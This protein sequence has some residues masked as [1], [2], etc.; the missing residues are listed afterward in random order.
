VI[1]GIVAMLW[2]A[3]IGTVQPSGDLN[4]TIKAFIAIVIGGL[5][6]I[7]G[8]VAGGLLLG[9]FETLLAA[10]LPANLLPYGEAFAFGLVILVLIARPQGVAGRI[11]ELSR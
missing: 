2:F 10:Y 8:A 5:G 9:A 11:V 6:S 3:K 4:P 7:R 1:A